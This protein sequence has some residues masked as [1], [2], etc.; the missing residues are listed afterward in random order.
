MLQMCLGQSNVARL[1]KTTPAD[2]L[3][4]GALNAG[5]R[6]ILLRECGC[7]L[8]LARGVQRLVLLLCLEAYNARLLL[9][10]CTVRPM[11]TQRAV[12]TGKARFPRHGMLGRGVREPRDALLPHRTRHDLLGPVDEKPSLVESK[13]RSGLPTGVVRYWPDECHTIGALT[14]HQDLGVCITL[15]DEVFRRQQPTRL[16]GRM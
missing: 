15:I 9:R 6:R 10:P 14:V 7:R 11:E 13:T 16:Q 12:F 3:R 5:S 8:A 4:V 2:A 1:S